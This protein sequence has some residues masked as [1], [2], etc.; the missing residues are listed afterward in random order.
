MGFFILT[1]TNFTLARRSASARRHESRLPAGRHG[2]VFVLGFMIRD[3]FS[4]C[5]PLTTNASRLTTHGYGRTSEQLKGEG[6][7]V[8]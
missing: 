5:L 7:C 8:V 1:L 3:G 4:C 6:G 2:H